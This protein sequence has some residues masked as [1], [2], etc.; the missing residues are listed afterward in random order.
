MAH[1]KHILL[2]ASLGLLSFHAAG[3]GT[4]PL[5]ASAFQE[6]ETIFRTAGGYGCSTCHGMYAHGGGNVGGN[7]RG[8]TLEQLNTRLDNE[9][10][11]QLLSSVLSPDDR[12]LLAHYLAELNK[13]QLIEWVLEESA[14]NTIG[15]LESDKPVQLVIFNKLLTPVS[16]DLSATGQQSPVTIKPYQTR[17]FNWTSTNAPLVLNYKSNYLTIKKP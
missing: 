6:G 7:I 15:K 8:K 13:Y 10:T 1:I 4:A 14:G 16:L 12:R 9:P 2:T 11:M 5:G 17:A 3:Q